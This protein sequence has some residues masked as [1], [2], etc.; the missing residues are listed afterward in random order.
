MTLSAFLIQIL[1]THAITLQH[2]AAYF[3]E[4]ALFELLEQSAEN[5]DEDRD[6]NPE[7]HLDLN[8]FYLPKPSLSQG[9]AE[10][11]GSV[12]D[13][14]LPE[15]LQFH[16]WAYPFY[17]K[18][19]ESSLDLKSSIQKDSGAIEILVEEAIHEA[20]VWIKRLPL[21]L[22]LSQHAQRIAHTPWIRFRAEVLKKSGKR[23]FQSLELIP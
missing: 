21:P 15:V 7:F 1:R 5:H 17:R 18:F 9:Y 11:E 16:L 12:L 3:G 6:L 23:P 10:I 13:L 2:L 22:P 4:E 20:Q 19:V 14:K 8:W